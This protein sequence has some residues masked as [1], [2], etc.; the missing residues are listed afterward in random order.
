[1]R[2]MLLIVL[3][4]VVSTLHAQQ[5]A[6][7]DSQM[8]GFQAITTCKDDGSIRILVNSSLDAAARASALVHELTHAGQ[9]VSMG[10][11]AANQQYAA[12]PMFR[13]RAELDAY[14]SEAR[15][16][17]IQGV[18]I[19]DSAG[20]GV[21][22]PMYMFLA[23]GRGFLSLDSTRAIVRSACPELAGP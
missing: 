9:M 12:D 10:C 17:R 11:A 21:P 4:C 7:V 8:A 16:H 15:V 14:C 13:L 20:Q 23:Y 22:F 18:V 1:M 19:A 5:I 3:L 2:K 6:V